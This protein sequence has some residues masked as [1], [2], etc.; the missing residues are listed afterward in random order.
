MKQ[1][2]CI[3]IGAGIGGMATAVRLANK[4]YHVVVLEKN[5]RPGGKI[6]EIKKDG[7]RFDTGPSLFTLPSLVDELLNI[8]STGDVPSFS[9]HQLDN[10]CRYFYEDGTQINAFEDPAEFADEINLQTGEPRKKIL[11]YLKIA[12]KRYEAASDI[13]IFNPLNKALEVSKKLNPQKL[14]PLMKVNPLRTMHGEN[15]QHFRSPQ[16]VQ[17]FDRYATYNGS[18][19]YLASSMLNMISHLEHNS[20][21]FFPDKGMYSIVEAIRKKAENSGIDFLFNTEVKELKISDTKVLSVRTNQGDFE[22]DLFIS[23]VDVNAFY[24]KP[25]ASLKAPKSVKNPSLS[26]SALIFY[27]GMDRSFPDLEVH[28]ILFSADYREEFKSLFKTRELFHDPTVY[29]FI[30]SKTI[31]SDAPPGK[32]NWFVMIN[33]PPLGDRNWEELKQVARKNIIEKIKRV[34]KTDPTPY[35]LFEEVATPHSIQE[36]TGSHKGALYGNNSNSIW[37]AFLRHKNQSTKYKN[38]FFTG[39]SVH[40]GGG[41]PLCLASASIVEKVIEKI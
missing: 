14:K 27:W 23:D 7:F 39:G 34:L 22:A 2:K 37:S 17:L 24:R 31:K 38:L 19:P 11:D 9:Y 18:S 4:G 41:I 15:K 32:E 36:F 33:V 5:F 26:S 3:I 21:A 12:Q 25:A 10:V 35:I 40:P 13:F 30:S 8:G 28:N 29:L 16:V 20:G 1:K 6:G